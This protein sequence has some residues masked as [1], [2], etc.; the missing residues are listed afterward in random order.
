MS[1][2]VTLKIFDN[3]DTEIHSL[4]IPKSEL[5]AYFQLFAVNT[6][7]KIR[8]YDTDNNLRLDSSININLG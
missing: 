7:N 3:S 5:T 6:D 2:T 4:E 8:V 1:Q